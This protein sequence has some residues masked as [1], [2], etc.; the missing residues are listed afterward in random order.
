MCRMIGLILVGVAVATAASGATA[1]T[2]DGKT[3]QGRVLKRGDGTIVFEVHMYGSTFNK[4]FKEGDVTITEDDAPAAA[5]TTRG[6]DEP[7]EA[8]RPKPPAVKKYAGATY[9]RIPLE[10]M[11]GK[12]FTAALLE[13]SLA[14]AASRE[15]TVVILEI[16]SPGG[17]ISEV[18]KIGAVLHRYSEKLRLVVLA[19]DA[20]SAAAIAAI[21]V[22]DVFI[23]PL[24]RIGAA[25]AWQ[26]GEDGMPTAIA[27]KFQSAWRATA[28]SMAEMGGHE[29]LLAEAMIDATIALHVV[30]DSGRKRIRRG[31]GET[32]VTRESRLLTMT[33][34]EA[35][36]AGLAR[37]KVATLDDLRG[38]LGVESWTECEGLAVP[39]AEWQGK[40][41]AR[42]ETAFKGKIAAFKTNLDSAIANDPSR[43]DYV[44][45]K[46]GRFT[47][48][49]R[50]KWR[51]LAGICTRF[52]TK[53]ET[54][55]DAAADLAEEYP[56][57]LTDPD[58]IRLEQEK[59]GS[60]RK[61]VYAEMNRQGLGG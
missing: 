3:Y 29:P 53:A 22:P 5:T 36:D 47:P 42:A 37:A 12:T 13:A 35:V 18:E 23:K 52:L 56:G 31:E 60:L 49:S 51:R 30:K 10:G 11:V 28:R 57:L 41:L 26:A 6:K 50:K 7:A 44:V 21:A 17:V 16:D 2:R 25:T 48:A 32:M 38:E 43:S 27:E 46:G 59:L 1:V 34:G 20:L 9:Y 19:E 8:R 61:R 15:P 33:A 14:D 45:H 39:L 4:T 58:M 55:L 54:N 40:R 24:G